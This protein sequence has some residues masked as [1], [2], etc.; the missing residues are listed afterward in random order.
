MPSYPA[1]SLPISTLIDLIEVLIS[2]PSLVFLISADTP[3]D[4]S[5]MLGSAVPLV[6]SEA[7]Q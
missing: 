7:V 4:V 3:P 5:R 2:S 6:P 1:G